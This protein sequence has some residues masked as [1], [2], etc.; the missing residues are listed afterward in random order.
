MFQCVRIAGRVLPGNLLKIHSQDLP[1]FLYAS[2]RCSSSPDHRLCLLVLA[3]TS[4]I[5]AA[6]IRI[7]VAQTTVVIAAGQLTPLRYKSLGSYG[8]AMFGVGY[9]SH[10]CG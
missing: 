7:A 1:S 8:F 6:R 10:P 5:V 2:K 9:V 4:I 3:G